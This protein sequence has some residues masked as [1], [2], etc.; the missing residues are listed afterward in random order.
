[1]AD[2]PNDFQEPSLTWLDDKFKLL[3]LGSLKA[4][5][6]EVYLAYMLMYQRRELYC[7]SFVLAD[8]YGMS[9]QKIRKLQIEFAKRF[10]MEKGGVDRI[11]DGIFN[12]NGD[13]KIILDVSENKKKI[14]FS[15][16]NAAWMHALKITMAENGLTWYEERN[17]RA[18][19]MDTHVFVYLFMDLSVPFGTALNRIFETDSSLREHGFTSLA[20]MSQGT[21]CSWVKKHSTEIMNVISTVASV[22]GTVGT[23]VK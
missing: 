7:D 6:L 13:D 17:P 5:E 3:T 12:K 22:I 15:V 4:S 18:V 11:V 23:F 9:E 19:T 10:S 14:T 16:K 1:M 20:N 2:K 21:I 8:K